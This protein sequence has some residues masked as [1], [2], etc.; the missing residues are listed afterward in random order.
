MKGLHKS[1]S[2]RMVMGVCGGIAESFGINSMLVRAVFVLLAI[3]TRSL[4][5][6]LYMM[7]GTMLPYGDAPTKPGGGQARPSSSY[8]PEAPPFDISDAMDVEIDS[9]ADQDGRP[10]N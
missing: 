7:L 3:Y 4:F 10:N 5:F 6:W 8:S 2:D 1:R 9:D